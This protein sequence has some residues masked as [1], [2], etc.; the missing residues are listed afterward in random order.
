MFYVF[1]TSGEDEVLIRDFDVKTRYNT[2]TPACNKVIS[3]EWV[4]G[5]LVVMCANV[6]LEQTTLVQGSPFVVEGPAHLLELR[7]ESAS[8]P[9]TFSALVERSE[10]A[11]RGAGQT[12]RQTRVRGRLRAADGP[13]RVPLLWTSASKRIV[14]GRV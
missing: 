2:K 13:C 9:R 6:M 8:G 12:V 4:A 10:Q 14:C 5:S 11:A 3:A 1:E 7:E